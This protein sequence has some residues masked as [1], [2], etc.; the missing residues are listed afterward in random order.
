M[1]HSAYAREEEASHLESE[2]IAARFACIFLV[3]FVF[4]LHSCHKRKLIRTWKD[5][6]VRGKKGGEGFQCI[7]RKY[8]L[9]GAR[10]R[11]ELE[12]R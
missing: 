11:G 4:S 2:T 7:A 5:K 8:I 1:F 12:N 9:R 3:I 6:R 10:E